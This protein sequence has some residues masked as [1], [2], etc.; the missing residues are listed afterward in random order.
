[1]AFFL[2][3]KNFKLYHSTGKALPSGRAISRFCRLSREAGAHV[4]AIAG[5]VTVATTDGVDITEGRAIGSIS[6]SCPPD[7]SGSSCA[8]VRLLNSARCICED[9]EDLLVGIVTDLLV[10]RRSGID[11]DLSG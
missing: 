5:R 8:V 11:A 6:R 7:L 3:L 2:S 10:V 9:A 1:M 4:I